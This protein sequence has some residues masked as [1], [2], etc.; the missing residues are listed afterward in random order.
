MGFR[1]CFAAATLATAVAA[2]ASCSSK[3]PATPTPTPTHANVTITSMT[4]SSARGSEGGYAYRTVLHLRETGGAAATIKAVDLTY[5]QGSTT[6]ITSHFDQPIS[7]TANVVPAGGVADTRELVTTDTN[8]SHP[9]ADTVNARVTYTDATA[10][11]LSVSGSAA[12]PPVSEPP[13]AQT[14]TLR[15]IITEQGTD[16]G[17]EGARVEALNG[18]NAGKA[19][20]TDT[21]GSY[22]LSGLVGETFRMRASASGFDPGEQNVTVPEITRA[23]LALKRTTP[24]ACA[25]TV[26]PSGTVDVSFQG[27][28]F[29]FTISRTSGTCAWQA[30]TNVTWISIGGTSGSGDATLTFTYQP[31]ASFVGRIGVIT[32]DWGTGSVQL[33]VRQ[34]AESPAFCRIVTVTVGGQN[35][36]SVPAAGNTYTAS[37]TPEAGTPPGACGAWTATAST[38][39]AFTGLTTGP[40]PGSVTFTVQPNSG[41]TPRALSVNVSISGGPSAV[42]NISQS[43]S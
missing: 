5:M 22:T 17:I 32:V 16:R 29:A 6:I 41:T 12:V 14:Y 31:N 23:D 3:S 35:S 10:A 20:L 37:I 36:I 4:V 34:A 13:P 33:T 27:G 21:A 42:L 15:G 8:A 1:R 24:A 25:Y 38:G 2:V 9:I 7:A 26:T 11:D 43:G 28:Q 30:S 18:A 40:T 19:T 39:I